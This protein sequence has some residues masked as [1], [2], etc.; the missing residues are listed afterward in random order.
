MVIQ[1]LHKNAVNAQKVIQ[2]T[3]R[4]LKDNLPTSEAHSALKYA[5]LTPFNQI[6]SE[7]IQQLELL[8]RKYI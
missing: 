7:R 1:N 3:V 8:L 6:P 4:R 5:I 2:E